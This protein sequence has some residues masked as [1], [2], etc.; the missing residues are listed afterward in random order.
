[1]VPFAGGG[2]IYVAGSDLLPELHKQ[3][4]FRQSLIQFIALAAGVGLIALTSAAQSS[5]LGHE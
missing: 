2:F 5:A 4:G 3:G 1:V